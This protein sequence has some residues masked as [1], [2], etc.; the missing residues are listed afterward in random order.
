MDWDVENANCAIR[1]CCLCTQRLHLCC[2][3][4]RLITHKVNLFRHYFLS[5]SSMRQ[6]LFTF[7]TDRVRSTRE[8]YVLTRVCPSIRLSVHRG[9]T[10]PGRG[11]VPQPGPAGGVPGPGSDQGGTPARSMGGLQP[12]PTGWGIPRRGGGEYPSLVQWGGYPAPPGRSTPQQG[13]PPPPR[14]RWGTWYGMPLAFT[15][16]DFLVYSLF[17]ILTRWLA[18]INGKYE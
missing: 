3:Q 11:G 9:G 18:R 14:W 8:G 10:P 5:F 13:Y 6:I 4:V 7:I 1:F 16:E 2:R 15:Q 12:G 17:I